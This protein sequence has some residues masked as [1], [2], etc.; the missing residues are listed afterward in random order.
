MQ[1]KKL[2][3]KLN[4]LLQTFKG[5]LLISFFIFL[6]AV[7]AF[8]FG[9]LFTKVS[10]LEKGGSSVPS[11]VA[12]PTG[13]G[14]ADVPTPKTVNLAKP[15]NKDHIR[16]SQNATIALIDYTDLSCPYCKS[17]NDTLKQ[18]LITYDGKVQLVLR[19]FPLINLHP[20]AQKQA[21]ASECVF[22]LSGDANFWTYTDQIYSSTAEV[23]VDVLKTMAANIGLDK[24]KFNT[25]L[26][27]SEM[28]AIVDA[29]IQSG[30]NAGVQGT[31]GDFL[32]N[33]KTGEFTQLQGAMPVA[34]L[35]ASIDTVLK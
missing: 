16:G 6:L 35:N 30:S 14:A 12:I 5:N 22:K 21:E 33:L 2:N 3:S 34:Q 7:Y 11:K 29:D 17:F 8:A 15:S 10:Y 13:N 32:M 20:N 9:V 24:T 25:C 23:T 31:P 1:T 26:D 4:F 28:K 27:S 18:I 19:H